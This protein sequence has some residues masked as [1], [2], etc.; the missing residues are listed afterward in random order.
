MNTLELIP[1]DGAILARLAEL[2]QKY[3]GVKRFEAEKILYSGTVYRIVGSVSDGN[4]SG[5]LYIRFNLSGFT[6]Y[7]M[8]R[9]IQPLG[10]YINN[11]FRPSKLGQFYDCEVER[12]LNY[13]LA[14]GLFTDVKKTVAEG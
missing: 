6:L 8:N 13:L 3:K 4:L 11:T 2:E 9:Y 12:V 1:R 5:R 14:H 7:L 10:E